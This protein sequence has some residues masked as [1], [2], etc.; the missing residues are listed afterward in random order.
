MQKVPEYQLQVLLEELTLYT[1]CD[2]IFDK[3]III[4]EGLILERM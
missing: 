2:G 3:P 4:A 1:G